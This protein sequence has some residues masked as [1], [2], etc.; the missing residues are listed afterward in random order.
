MQE[1]KTETHRSIIFLCSMSVLTVY[2]VCHHG[3][4]HVKLAGA[5]IA[6]VLSWDQSFLV[7]ASFLPFGHFLTGAGLLKH[8]AWM[9]WV[10]RWSCITHSHR[11]VVKKCQKWL[12]GCFFDGLL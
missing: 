7:L 11:L 9:V 12:C 1:L 6:V 3:F 4:C 10:S 8:S 2:D 5:V